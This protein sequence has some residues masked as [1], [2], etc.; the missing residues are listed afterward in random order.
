MSSILA[1]L[2]EYKEN[3]A[4]MI[5]NMEKKLNGGSYFFANPIIEEIDRC[6]LFQWH[7]TGTG[8]RI[9]KTTT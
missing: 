7:S 1:Q 8:S 4:A 5:M 9:S 6:R 3:Q 2:G